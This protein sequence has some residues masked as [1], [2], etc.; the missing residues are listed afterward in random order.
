VSKRNRKNIL[1][2]TYDGKPGFHVSKSE[3][4]YMVNSLRPSAFILAERPLELQLLNSPPEVCPLLKPDLSLI[5]PASVIRSAAQR[6]Q[7]GQRAKAL[8]AGWIPLLDELRRERMKNSLSLA[9]IALFYRGG[10]TRERIRAI[11]SAKIVSPAVKR[12]YLAAIAA[13]IAD[14]E[15]KR[16]ILTRVEVEMNQEELTK[17]KSVLSSP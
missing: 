13:A 5:M 14:V 3:A 7:A 8:V 2:R 6:G 1:V 15:R 10:R 12:D 16:R 11:E 4:D 9:D 17:S